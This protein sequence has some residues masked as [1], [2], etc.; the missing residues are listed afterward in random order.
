MG[1]TP[2]EWKM[3]TACGSEPIAS[4]T[5][6]V[7]L[8]GDELSKPKREA[9]GSIAMDSADLGSGPCSRSSDTK[10][11]STRPVYENVNKTPLKYK[12]ILVIFFT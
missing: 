7:E 11:F 8:G 1:V 3:D 4:K 12:T 6:R 2:W 9:H 10:A 5:F